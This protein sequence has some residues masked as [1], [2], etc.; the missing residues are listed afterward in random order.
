MLAHNRW[1]SCSCDWF[2]HS[3]VLGCLLCLWSYHSPGVAL[4]ALLVF[5]SFSSQKDEGCGQ[6]LF[7]WWHR[8]VFE[9]YQRDT[10]NPESSGIFGNNLQLVRR[11]QLSCVWGSFRSCWEYLTGFSWVAV[12]FLGLMLESAGTLVCY[13]WLMQVVIDEH[14]FLSSAL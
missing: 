13:L 1:A 5:I 3:A 10:E 14:L 8:L 11:L 12:H 4:S 2:S 9:R 7:F 6:C